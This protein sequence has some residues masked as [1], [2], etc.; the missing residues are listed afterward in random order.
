MIDEHLEGNLMKPTHRSLCFKS[1]GRNFT[2]IT[3]IIAPC[4]MIVVGIIVHAGELLRQL[5]R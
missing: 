3:V 5:G 1:E 2:G 4:G